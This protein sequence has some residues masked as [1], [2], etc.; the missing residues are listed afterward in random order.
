MAAIITAVTDKSRIGVCLDTCHLF[1]AGYDIR[2]QKKFEDVMAKFDVTVGIKYLQGVHLNDSKGELGS[3]KDRH[4][5]IGKGKI[6]LEAFRFIMNS[7]LFDGIPM[8]L[9]TPVADDQSDEEIY[10]K[11]ISL[12]YSLVQK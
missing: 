8:I 4:E 7:P 6:G 2:T 3:C 11:E 12:L 10:S 9:E 1:A 5:N